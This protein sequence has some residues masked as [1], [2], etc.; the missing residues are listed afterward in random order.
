MP[1]HYFFDMDDTLTPSRTPMSE[2]HSRIF[3]QLCNSKDVVVVSGAQE[4]QILKQLPQI[5]ARYYM[6]T[7]S[8]NRAIGPDKNILWSESF[9]EEQEA[10]IRGLIA[11]WK[12][13]LALEVQDEE[14]LVEH[15]G[16]QISYSLIGHD[17]DRVKKAAFDPRGTFRRQVLAE[18]EDDIRK[19]HDAGVEITIAGTTC[20]DFILLGKN[21]GYHV[22][23]LIGHMGWSK[24]DSIY[25]GDAL[26]P[27][28]ND[29]TVV[30]IIPTHAVKN[31]DETFEFIRTVLS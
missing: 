3:E 7:Q 31:P 29:E 12:T 9:T 26:E 11:Q 1:K 17:E 19:L 25:V 23:K 2:A 21:K 5:N 4:S 10:H 18:S 22:A 20:F 8:G 13:R 28:R 27:G 14:N 6:L 30:G 16:S 15:R 24:E